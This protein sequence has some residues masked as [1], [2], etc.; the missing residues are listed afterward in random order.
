MEENEEEEDEDDDEEDEKKGGG[1]K[2][3]VEEGEVMMP[4][5]IGG[6][7]RLGVGKRG[8]STVLG[9]LGGFVSK[10]F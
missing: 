6:A 10:R 7:G 3:G 4:R 9:E 8:V 1:R 5:G 2:E